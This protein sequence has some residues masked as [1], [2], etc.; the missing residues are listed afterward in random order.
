MAL[1]KSLVEKTTCSLDLVDEE[2]N[3]LL[4]RAVIAGRKEM[5]KYISRKCDDLVTQWNIYG[6]A[7]VH[8]AL[9]SN[10]PGLIEA[11]LWI[12]LGKSRKSQ[13]IKTRDDLNLLQYIVKNSHPTILKLYFNNF[14]GKRRSLKEKINEGN[15]FG[16][17]AMHLAAASGNREILAILYNNGG[18]LNVPDSEGMLPFHYAI[19]NGFLFTT[20]FIATLMV[21]DPKEIMADNLIVASVC[22]HKAC[23]NSFDPIAVKSILR[24]N[25]TLLKTEKEVNDAIYYASKNKK[26]SRELI[27]ILLEYK[28]K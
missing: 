13:D 12:T 22:F 25:S 1:L 6:L 23:E 2:G 17:T 21:K 28:D 26:L 3:N 7:P 24:W 15:E 14:A 19:S 20:R 27:E 4:H 11:L 5:A 10:R 18:D 16:Q 8:L 9:L